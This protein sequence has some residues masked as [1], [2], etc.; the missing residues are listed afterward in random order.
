[1]KKTTGKGKA[2]QQTKVT[3][4]FDVGMLNVLIKYCLCDFIPKSQIQTLYKLMKEIDPIQYKEPDVSDRIIILK[5]LT[6]AIIEKNITDIELLRYEVKINSGN[7]APVLDK[8]S[9]ERNQIT[10]SD[11]EAVANAIEERLQ[12]IYIY[13]SNL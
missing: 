9:F 7:S 4:T 1:M 10:L 6:E 2:S 3:I 13:E 5:S 11:S 12:T 8:I